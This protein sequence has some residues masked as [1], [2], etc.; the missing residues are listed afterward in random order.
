MS[1]YDRWLD[2]PDL[3]DESDPTEEDAE[4]DGY[5]FQAGDWRSDERDLL[6]ERRYVQ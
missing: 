6:L 5:P 3:D 1:A 2:P 4:P